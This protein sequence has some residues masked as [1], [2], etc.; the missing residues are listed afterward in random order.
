MRNTVAKVKLE[1]SYVPEGTPIAMNEALVRANGEVWE[2]HKTDADPY[3]SDPHAHN[4]NENLKLD[5]RNGDLWRG[6]RFLNKSMKPKHLEHLRN[7]F[8]QKGVVLPTLD[9]STSKITA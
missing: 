5:F 6:S 9:Y 8:E 4:Y 2:V 3:P 7:E 1:E